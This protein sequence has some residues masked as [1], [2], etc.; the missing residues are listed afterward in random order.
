MI[1]PRDGNHACDLTRIDL[2]V[3]EQAAPKRVW[4]L[5]GDCADNISAGNPHADRF[6]NNAVWHFYTDTIKT[7]DK[8]PTIPPNSL[9]A[10]WLETKD[11]AQAAQL[12]TEVET[13]LTSPLPTDALEPNETLHRE[14]TALNGPLFA[15]IDSSK[16][17]ESVSAEEL[18]SAKFGL[19][20]QL[21]GRHPKGSA[22]PAQHL[23]VQAPS[24]LEIQLPAGLVAGSEF[25]VLCRFAGCNRRASQRAVSGR[26]G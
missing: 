21:F 23:V 12:A 22:V 16:L 9:L 11:A 19:D 2:T 26:D 24:I 14:L 18:A 25:T 17:L 6:D 7:G 13:L 5:S 8:Q 20:P 15:T 3:S 10:R 4:S 1:G